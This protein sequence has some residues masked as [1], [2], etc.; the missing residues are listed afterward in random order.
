MPF[1]PGREKL[2]SVL[3]KDVYFYL[4]CV[5]FI[6]KPFAEYVSLKLLKESDMLL[7]GKT[8]IESVW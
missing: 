5:L 2:K 6:L 3:L 1:F 4:L 7:H 8:K